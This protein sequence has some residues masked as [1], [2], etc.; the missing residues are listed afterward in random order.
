[1]KYEVVTTETRTAW[2][3]VEAESKEQ[4]MD[5]FP[6]GEEV[7]SVIKSVTIESVEAE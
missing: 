6:D 5:L 7:D 2:Y 3:L 4:A 1:M